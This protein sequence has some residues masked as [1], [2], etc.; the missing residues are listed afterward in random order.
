MLDSSSKLPP[1]SLLQGSFLFQF[2]NFDECLS[3]NGPVNSENKPRFTGKYC[4]VQLG[5]STKDE[6]DE[7]SKMIFAKMKLAYDKITKGNNYRDFNGF[8]N[9]L[10]PQSGLIPNTTIPA[11]WAVCAPSSCNAE[12]VKQVADFNLKQFFSVLGLNIDTAVIENSC[13]YEDDGK[14]DLDTGSWAFI[15]LILA[16]TVFMAY[17]TICDY[18]W[19]EGQDLHV[20]VQSFSLRTNLRNLFTL[21]KTVVPGQLACLHG[22]RVVSTW[23]IILLHCYMINSF[24]PHINAYSHMWSMAPIYS[25]ALGVDT[26][27]FMSGLLTVY[28]ILLDQKKGRSFNVFKYI[29][30]RYLRITLPLAMVVF[31]LSTLHR[32]VGATPTWDLFI[33]PATQ[34]CADYWWVTLLYFT[35]FFNTIE[36]TCVSQGWYL[37]VDMQLAVLA[38]IVIFP[39]L[40]WPKIGLGLIGVL[41]LGSMAVSFGL[42][43]VYNL[44]WTMSIV[45]QNEA[46]GNFFEL[47][48]GNPAARAVPYLCGMALA[49]VLAN[50]IT[51]KLPKWGVVL[52]W[53]LNSAGCLAIIYTILIIYDRN[54][55]YDN[56]DAAFYSAL[57]RLGWASGLSWVVW[58]C[59]NGYGGPVNSIL[60]WKYFIPLSKLSFCAYL[61]HMDLM[62]YHVALMRTNTYFSNFE[63]IFEFFGNL[64]MMIPL[65]LW[66]YLAVDAPCQSIIRA[67]FGKTNR[68][69]APTVKGDQNNN[70]KEEKVEKVKEDNDEAEPTGEKKAEE[71][72]EIVHKDS[73]EAGPTEENKAEELQEIDREDNDETEA[74]EEKNEEELQDIMHGDSDEA[75]P[76]EEEKAEELKEI[77]REDNDETDIIDE[78]N[79]EELHEIK[80]H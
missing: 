30:F 72:Q 79:D 63:I 24:L 44:Q 39:L 5:F 20:V 52:E 70:K 46:T 60:S 61:V 3:V 77:D 37:M 56:L 18:I 22:I 21:P 38:P 32:R 54:F 12:G 28:V 9:I 10:V 26:F 74:I 73:D 68:F 75:S 50:K 11:Q 47:I 66:L 35:N 36:T 53:I 34:N 1:D 31:Y 76:T 7:K 17:A 27:F 58:A 67:A 78:E 8:K 4:R 57:H 65:T 29:L 13:H 64:I 6:T 14:Q 15:I 41:T 49:Y 33:E 2:G 40:K 25:G 62:N 23:W 71:L 45:I 43:Y 51:Y 48:Y 16:L 59:V 69:V 19:P 42:T 80:S 55:V